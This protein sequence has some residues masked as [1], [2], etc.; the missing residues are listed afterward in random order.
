MHLKASFAFMSII[1]F[2]TGNQSL[3]C[4]DFTIATG[5]LEDLMIRNEQQRHSHQFVT[6]IKHNNSKKQKSMFL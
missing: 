3:E 4:A 6:N 2:N 1:W 5:M